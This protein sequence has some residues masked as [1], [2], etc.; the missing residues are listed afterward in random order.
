MPKN[1]ANEKILREIDD[2][3]LWFHAKKYRPIWVRLLEKQEAVPTLEGEELVPAGNYVCRGE[4]GDIWP[5]SA[6]KLTAKYEL[7]DELDEQGWRK[8]HPKPDAAGVVAAQILHAFQVQAEWG[9]LSGKPGDFIVKNFA[10]RN[11][12]NPTD[13]WIVD[14]RLFNATYERVTTGQ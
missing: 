3:G 5:Q 2:A 14:Q 11:N 9:T 12:P 7:T 13:V 4:A 6:E 1:N 8:C 10:D